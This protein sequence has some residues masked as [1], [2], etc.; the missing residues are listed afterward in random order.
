MQVIDCSQDGDAHPRNCAWLEYAASVLYAVVG[1]GING[2]KKALCSCCYRWGYQWLEEG[3]LF[4]L[5]ALRQLLMFPSH[6]HAVGRKAEAV[7]Q[8]VSLLCGSGV[9]AGKMCK[10][11]CTSCFNE[12]VSFGAIDQV[13]VNYSQKKKYRGEGHKNIYLISLSSDYLKITST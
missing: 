4:L 11:V 9:R 7:L 6:Q 12:P 8:Q 13:P 1:Q 10:L 3:S 5:L 2:S